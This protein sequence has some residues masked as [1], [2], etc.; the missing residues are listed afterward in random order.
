MLLP[1]IG[2]R[3]EDAEKKTPA[4]IL[5]SLQKQRKN[6]GIVSIKEDGDQ[7]IE[8]QNSETDETVNEKRKLKEKP[9]HEFVGIKDKFNLMNE[10]EIRHSLSKEKKHN[11]LQINRKWS[12]KQ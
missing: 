4:L 5:L 3:E 11:M 12:I 10:R 9:S 8:I 6:Q 2:N 1:L 7:L